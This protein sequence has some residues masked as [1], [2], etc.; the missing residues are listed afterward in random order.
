M[1]HYT[2]GTPF[3]D[4]LDSRK[5]WYRT[6]VFHSEYPDLDGQRDT[7]RCVGRGDMSDNQGVYDSRCCS[8]WLNIGHTQALHVQRIQAAEA[9]QKQ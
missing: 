8:C 7:F 3:A 5:V 4:I 6:D 2:K 1:S 9:L